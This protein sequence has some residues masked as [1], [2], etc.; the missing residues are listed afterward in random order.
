MLGSTAGFGDVTPSHRVAVANFLLILV[1]LSVVSMAINVVQMQ[2]EIVFAKVVQ[3]IDNDFKMN[4]SVSGE[5]VS[6]QQ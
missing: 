1:G 3:S 6:F 5:F 4:L 2:L